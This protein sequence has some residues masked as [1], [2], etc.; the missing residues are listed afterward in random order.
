MKKILI[1][2]F[3]FNIICVS[4]QQEASNWYFGENAGIKFNLDGSISVLNNGQINTREGC[5]SISDRNGILLFYT[6]GETV[7]N[8][9]HVI[10]E[11]GNGLLGDESSTQSAIVVPKPDDE[12]IYY[13][14]TVGS[15]QN[16]TGLNYSIV[17]MTLDGGLGAITQ[18]NINLINRCSEK[19][20]AVLADCE[21][22][23]ILLIAFSNFSGVYASNQEPLDTFHVFEIT[24]AGV[25]SNA[26]R[27]T[28]PGFF[29]N[30]PRGYLKL[31]PDGTKLACANV[32]NGLFLYDFDTQ[33]RTVSNPQLLTINNAI[34]QPYGIEF[35]PN[36]NLLYVT[37]SNDYFAQD[38]TAE[39]PA[40]HQSVLVQFDLTAPDIVASQ[41]LIDIRQL[42]RGGLQLA[43]DGKIYRALSATY[44]QGLGYLG[45]INNPNE[46]GSACDYEHNALNLG[47]NE[48][49][50]GLPPFIQSFFNEKID[51][52]RNGE[53]TT[54]YLALCE[55]ESYTLTA[56]DILDAEYTWYLDGEIIRFED[57][58][59]LDISE[60]G[61]Y[62]V[63]IELSTGDCDIIEGEATIDFFSFPTALDY[64]LFQCDEDGNPDG[65][66]LF[67]L[68]EAN[69]YITND[70]PDRII[71][72]YES[73]ADAQSA[74][75]P[76]DSSIY[77]NTSNPQTL[78]VEVIDSQAGCTSYSELTLEVSVTQLNDLVVDVC[79]ENDSEDGINTFE[80]FDEIVNNILAQIPTSGLTLSFYENYD[81][82]LIEQ[83]EITA[84][85]TNTNAYNQTI[86]VRAENDNACYGISEVLLRINPLPQLLDDETL[87]YCLN[88]YPETI[89]LDAGVIDAD[90][91]GYSFIWSS[92]EITETI[93]I[94]QTGV[95][96][97]TVT[98]SFGCSNGRTITV[99][100]S[101][102]ATFEN[103][104]VVDG[105]D[106]FNNI[107]TVEVSGEG[108]YQYALSNIPQN[109]YPI[110]QDENIFGNVFPGIYTVL[111]RDIKNDCGIVEE[112]IS[113]IGFPQYFTP[114]NDGYNDTWQVYG[115]SEQF[116]PNSVIYI[117]D[118]F[119]K[120][121]K[122]LDPKDD[123]WDGTFNGEP[124][125][126]ND[127]WFEVTLQD[128]RKFMDHFT[129]K[130]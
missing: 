15:N 121:L 24:T 25:N 37:A 60:S 53:T 28:I 118:R 65:E 106:E 6:D 101:N 46:I 44:T 85:Y 124:L 32:N 26:Q 29:A 4:A 80:S 50:Q 89:I 125:P 76:I 116:Q 83:N 102:I 120:L 62:E 23:T 104:T 113:V 59:T 31:S 40:N 129:L 70:E 47:T 72:Y 51:I 20:S 34:N 57:G 73:F 98:N 19:I 93:E 56:D 130:R 82:A 49:S 3:L 87:Y 117:Y 11:N 21:T 74:T 10:M 99:E 77:T 86:Y 43:P 128:G 18:K 22:E 48:S 69:N 111:V 79:D 91:T 75:N 107:V 119:G 12:D 13:I 114:N 103:I 5:S 108:T 68:N 38:G 92:G 7:F 96:T 105:S 67:N 36:N 33:T 88:S 30:D 112:I 64:T 42:Y 41:V 39:I 90:T 61:F 14:F 8:S 55:G 127:Y 123:G 109:I 27:T 97:I 94:N 9:N 95:Y 1:L 54:T 84:P 35:S 52:I 110:F 17:D 63:V 71:N 81:D 66:T 45:A 58:Y 122:Q 16:P 2:L 126:N 78:Y 100:P 115:V